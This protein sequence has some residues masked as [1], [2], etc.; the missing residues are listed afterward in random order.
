M[1]SKAYLAVVASPLDQVLA[2]LGSLDSFVANEFTACCQRVDAELQEV[3][4]VGFELES[5]D[6]DHLEA[7]SDMQNFDFDAAERLAGQTRR[8]LS[9]FRHAVDRHM[10]SIGSGKG[11]A[12]T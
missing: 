11:C 1:P 7:T 2:G 5:L 12:H 9:A 4:L 6:F 3:P 10:C 8:A